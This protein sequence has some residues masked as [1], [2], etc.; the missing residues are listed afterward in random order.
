[1]KIIP[2]ILSFLAFV[3]AIAIPPL[4]LQYAGNT[5]L[6]VNNFWT[7]F[8]FMSGLTLLVLAGMLL[9]KQ[10]DQ[11]YFTPAFLAG[12]TIKLLAFL[13]F[14]FVFVAKNVTNKHVF[15]ADFIYIYLLNTAFEIYV[16]L[17]NLRHEKLR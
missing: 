3:V 13:I 7:I 5:S 14:I 15:L 4:L 17:R 2:S 6:L 11:E 8:F 12:T 16:L 9:A 10:K 1:M